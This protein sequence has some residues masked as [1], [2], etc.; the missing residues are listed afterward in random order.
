[1][2]CISNKNFHK[3]QFTAVYKKTKDWV[4]AW[5][6]E[7]PGVNTQGKTMKEAR[8]NL[9]E[10]LSLVLEENRSHSRSSFRK[11]LATQRERISVTLSA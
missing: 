11:T 10:A 4:I 3:S 9:H 5:V 6:E 1:M 8:E 2:S 7:I